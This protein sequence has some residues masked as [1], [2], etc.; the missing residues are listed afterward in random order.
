MPNTMPIRADQAEPHD[1]LQIADGGQG[2]VVQQMRRPQPIEPLAVQ[3]QNQADRQDVDQ[4]GLAAHQAQAAFEGVRHRLKRISIFTRC[5]LE[6]RFRHDDDQHHAHT[7]QQHAAQH[8]RNVDP[9]RSDQRARADADQRSDRAD[10]RARKNA[11]PASF[12]SHLI[13]DPRFRRAAGEG[14]TQSAEHLRQ[15]DRHEERK[16]TFDD[17]A[18]PQ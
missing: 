7:H 15:Q 6:A 8:D 5:G 12:F 18:Q 9:Q 11:L 13:G 17:E 4:R 2:D 14:V 3:A 1:G 16:R 10:L